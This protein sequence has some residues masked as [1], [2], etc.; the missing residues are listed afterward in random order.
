MFLEHWRHFEIRVGAEI[1][2]ELT[3][4]RISVAVRAASQNARKLMRPG[5]RIITELLASGTPATLMV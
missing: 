5:S 1:D 2:K 3:L 4:G